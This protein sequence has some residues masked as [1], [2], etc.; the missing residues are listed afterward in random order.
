MTLINRTHPEII[1]SH[2]GARRPVFVS[3]S[4][5]RMVF[6]KAASIAYSLAAGMFMHF[7]N[8]GTEWFFI[9]N[10]NPDGFR[11]LNSTRGGVMIIDHG[12]MK[13]FRR[14]T[15]FTVPVRLFFAPADRKYDTMTM[16]E[17]FTN[18]TYTQ[19]LKAV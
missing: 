16:F 8:E 5:K 14:S 4:E 17:I 2:N 12:L 11:L 6:T 1:N 15:K 7:I 18:K 9:L 13:M 10:D 3:I 19:I